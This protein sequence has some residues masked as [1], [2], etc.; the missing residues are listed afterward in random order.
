M[1]L[2]NVEE[3]ACL[4]LRH[5]FKKK[6][7]PDAMGGIEILRLNVL[8]PLSIVSCTCLILGWERKSCKSYCV[9]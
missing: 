8:E 1:T 5:P 2:Y 3:S 7:T 6:Q 9:C 4:G